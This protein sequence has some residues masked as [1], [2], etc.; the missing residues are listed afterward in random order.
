MEKTAKVIENNNLHCFLHQIISKFG[1]NFKT[2][3]KHRP[4]ISIFGEKKH[5][6]TMSNNRLQRWAIHHII[7]D[8]EIIYVESENNCA[9]M[10]LYKPYFSSDLFRKFTRKPLKKVMSYH[11][12]KCMSIH[13][14][15]ECLKVLWAWTMVVRIQLAKEVAWRRQTIFNRSVDQ[16]N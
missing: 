16:Q 13:A 1:R 7:F 9:D 8:Y 10:I 3:N 6:S 15:G 4:I 11:Y 12:V 5:T 14:P 2:D